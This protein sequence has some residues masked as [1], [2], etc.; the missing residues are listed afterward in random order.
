MR[1][2][3]TR[4]VILS[5][6]LPLCSQAAT[7][8]ERVTA[9]ENAQAVTDDAVADAN[10]QLEYGAKIS[11]YVDAE[12]RTQ[13][14]SPGT[15]NGFRL[16]HTNLM[17]LNKFSEE[18]SFFS[19]IEFEDGTQYEIANGV[20]DTGNGNIFVEKAGF[21]Y[22]WKPEVTVRIGR[23]MTPIGIWNEDHYSP[24]VSTQD[25]PM[26]VENIFPGT[27]N[28]L[29]IFGTVPVGSNFVKYNLYTG[30]GSDAPGA[31]DNNNNKSVGARATFVFPSLHRL[32]AGV[33]YYK[34]TL[35]DTGI[36]DL[37]KTVTGMHF[38]FREGPWAVQAEYAAGKEDPLAGSQTEST[39]AYIQPQ[40]TMGKWTFGYRYDLYD[41]DSG[42]SSTKTEV[43][44]NVPYINYRVLPNL[45]LKV[46]H[47]MYSYDDPATQDSSMTVFSVAAFL[48]S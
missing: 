7:L 40:Y 11:G 25:R 6:M 46:E 14:D 18:W 8:E 12:Y 42:D 28:G 39:G 45:V 19:E 27:T 31:G 4:A 9:L 16:H 26:H 3:I 41:P 21:D 44:D 30:N 35:N 43:V 22:K 17:I 13:T 36:G 29:G 20:V 38:K 1:R 5:A 48:G 2:S 37:D 24:F 15:Y 10:H 33:S 23:F 32:E 47:H 34:D